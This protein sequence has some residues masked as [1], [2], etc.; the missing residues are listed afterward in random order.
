MRVF[1]KHLEDLSDDEVAGFKVPAGYPLVYELDGDL[2]P[3]GSRPGDRI[4]RANPRR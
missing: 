2:R 4:R 1:I 3:A